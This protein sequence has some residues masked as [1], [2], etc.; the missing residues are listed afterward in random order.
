M[1]EKAVRAVQDLSDIEIAAMAK[2]YV[3]KGVVSGG[4]WPLS[5]L[6]L[7]QSR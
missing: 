1:I 2:N 4:V 3:K 7:E 5:D 6:R